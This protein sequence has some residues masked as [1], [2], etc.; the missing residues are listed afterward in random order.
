MSGSRL[1]KRVRRSGARARTSRSVGVRSR[2]AGRRSW[3]SGSVSLEKLSRRWKV[4][5]DSSRKVG[6]ILNVCASASCWLEVASKVSPA[7]TIEVVQLALVL[8][9][10]PEDLAGAA[11]EARDLLG[12]A[13]EH[14]EQVVAVVGEG[15]QVAQR[16]V[17]VAPA[18]GDRLGEVLLPALEALA[19]LGV[20]RLEDLVEL[21]R[22]GHARVAEEAAVGHRARRALVAR[23]H[24]DVGLA[25]QRLLA[26]DR[27]RVLGDRRVLAGDLD[28]RDGAVGMRRVDRLVA[29][30]AD[31]HAGHAHVGLEAELRG[32]GEGDLE[33]VALGLERDR[34]AEAEPQEQQQ[35]EARQ[36]EEHHREDPAER[37]GLLLHQL[38]PADLGVEERGQQRL[39]ER[40]VLARDRLERRRRCRPASPARNGPLAS[41]VENSEAPLCC[42]H[43]IQNR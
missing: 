25:Q 31:A 30:L 35:A 38:R 15:G 37:G 9:E 1:T 16:V 36:G 19:R 28:R 41:E 2:A 5:L 20:E 23:R 13:V 34:A 43:A 26:Q 17:E 22:L 3:T 14:G 29:H 42:S 11:H 40:R 10:R 32:L 33:L 18:A 12:L 27:A 4:A 7:L 24:L 6:K 8:R 21:D 39:V